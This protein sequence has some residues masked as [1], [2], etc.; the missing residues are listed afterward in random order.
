MDPVASHLEPLVWALAS[1]RGRVLELGGGGYSTGVI[2]GFARSG[3]ECWTVET[4]PEWARALTELYG[5]AVRIVD[6][7][8]WLEWGVVLVDNAPG[9]ARAPA[10]RRHLGSAWIVVHDTEPEVA[11]FYPGMAEAIAEARTIRTFKYREPLPWTT[12]LLP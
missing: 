6:E 3:R 9:A 10:I 11:M 8:P 5:E 2:A 7:E 1:T 12:I 4:N